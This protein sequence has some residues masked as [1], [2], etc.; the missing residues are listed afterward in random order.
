MKN[1]RNESAEGSST[2]KIIGHTVR[3][4]DVE[5]IVLRRVMEE[6]MPLSKAKGEL[7]F[8]YSGD[9]EIW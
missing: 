4:E 7:V 3:S 9:D 5:N 8:D 1:D 6:R 2:V